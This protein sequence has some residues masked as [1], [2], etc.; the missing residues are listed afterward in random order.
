MTVD[1]AN[2]VA[3][4]AAQWKAQLTGLAA[5]YMAVRT[6]W[7]G[8]DLPV[9]NNHQDRPQEAAVKSRRFRRRRSAVS[10]AEYAVGQALP[11]SSAGS[12]RR[13][14]A[15]A[16]RSRWRCAAGCAGWGS[17]SGA[18]SVC[19]KGMSGDSGLTHDSTAWISVIHTIRFRVHFRTISS[20]EPMAEGRALAGGK[21]PTALSQTRI[22]RS[23]QPP[24]PRS[25]WSS[26]SSR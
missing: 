24:R 7:P 15:P 25:G 5:A 1:E 21:A 12:A 20:A 10:D 22:G 8:P 18:V 26:L 16:A 6:G 4:G 19:S 2:S 17:S 3:G 14:A 13:S 9:S 11:P 23:A